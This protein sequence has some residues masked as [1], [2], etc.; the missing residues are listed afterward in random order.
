MQIVTLDFETF[1]GKQY[2]LTKLTTEEYIHD[3]R[4]EAIGVATKINENETT[5]CS[6][7]HSEIQNYLDAIDW[8][9]SIMVAHNAMFD[10]AILSWQ[11]GIKPKRI[12]DT[13]SMSRAIDGVNVKHSLAAASARHGLGQ[14]GTEVVA[15]LGK[16]RKDFDTEELERYGGYCIN[17]VE[18]CFRLFRLYAGQFSRE[19]LEIVNLTIKMFSEPVLELDSLLLEQHLKV[20]KDTKAE[21]ITAA[22][23]DSETLQS[24]PKFAERLKTLGVLP[25]T[26]ISIRTGKETFAFAKNDKGMQELRE[27]P[28]HAVQ[29]L[30][31]ARLGVKSTIEE[32]RTERLLGIAQRTGVLPVPLRYYAAHTGR[33]GGS[34][35]LN[36]QN[37]PT[38]KGNTIKQ[39]ITAPEGC[40]LIDADSAQIE[41]RVLAW[42]AG[43]TDLVEAFAAE[44]DVY[45]IMAATIYDK[46]A[47]EISKSE[48]FVGK[49]VVLGS[50]YGM[51]A[52]KFKAQL[53]GFGVEIKLD[54]A[55]RIIN[56]YRSNYSDIPALW[57]DG[58]DC[59]WAI[60]NDKT[61]TLGV[62]PQVVY[63]D[64]SAISEE[65]CFVLPNKMML[66]YPVLERTKDFEY[67]YL[68]K[69]NV[70][71][72]IYGGKVI[73]NVCQA[74]ARCII[75]WQM[76]KIAKK[77]KVALTV[78]DSIVCAVKETEEEE[79][80]SY[81]ETVMKTPPEWATGLPLNC[82]I[83]IGRS[84]GECQ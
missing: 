26:K 12:A 47:A 74:I 71:T 11:F 49:S 67:S 39:A 42:L 33:W 70:R 16:Q 63:L 34:D 32:T 20:I 82:D 43:Q 22:S 73:E 40:L 8:D 15:A 24:N 83:G 27:H 3:Y 58:Q 59:L 72:K 31:S 68:A 76:L 56:T 28:D 7:D 50:G 6:G 29:A 13:L 48:R 19:E 52:K 36:M 46:P 65:V 25:P 2:S 62:Q 17:D 38:R 80:S 75:S 44:Q 51:G 41:A 21:L 64:K 1:Y 45:K 84:Y 23:T 18:L 37:L 79:A 55:Q 14:K 81:I 69:N 53:W 61:R 57:K 35:K 66:G 4:F 54:E 30:V 77:Y 9:D 78:H 5:W 60:L 10:A